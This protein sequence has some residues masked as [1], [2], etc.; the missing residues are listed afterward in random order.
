[1]RPSANNAAY[2]QGYDAYWEGRLIE[3]NPYEPD[4]DDF[5]RWQEG[6]IDARNDDYDERDG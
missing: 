4:T 2:A 6:W 1:M 5:R 3:A